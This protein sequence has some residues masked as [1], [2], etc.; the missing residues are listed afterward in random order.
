ML[1]TFIGYPFCHAGIG[2][3][4]MT[5]SGKRKLWENFVY[6]GN[7][8]QMENEL[9]GL[10]EPNDQYTNQTLELINIYPSGLL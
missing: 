1:F 10:A 9:K 7:I 8:L 3:L 5:K 6:F 2:P 4:I